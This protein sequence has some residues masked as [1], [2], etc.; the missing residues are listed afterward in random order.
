MTVS[1]AILRLCAANLSAVLL[2]AVST[3]A[4]QE[5][6]V[7]PAE[8]EFIPPPA[9]SAV[10]SEENWEQEL[11][12]LRARI[13]ELE[14]TNEKQSKAAAEKKA[15]DSRKPTIKWTGQLEADYY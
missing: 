15:D 10:D 5:P 3:A 9:P 1:R 8:S 2:I 14:S 13:D 4:G 6:P 11:A 12:S 7:L